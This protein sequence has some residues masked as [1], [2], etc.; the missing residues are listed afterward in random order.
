MPARTREAILL[1]RLRKAGIKPAVD[2]R[3]APFMF[4]ISPMVTNGVNIGH[5]AFDF[6]RETVR[7]I[8][9]MSFASPVP[10]IVFF[11]KILDPKMIQSK[12]FVSYKRSD[13]S[14][15]VGVNILFDEWTKSSP[16][17][18]VDMFADNLVESVNRISPK[19][20]LPDDRQKLLAVLQDVR[21]TVK[22]SL[23]N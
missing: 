6:V 11:P 4:A 16:S 14:V 9:G 15:Q 1:E 8:K 12:D 19:R 10:S 5:L 18:R 20:L 22:S 2:Q 17:E 23:L 13:R 3:G 21:R 7:R